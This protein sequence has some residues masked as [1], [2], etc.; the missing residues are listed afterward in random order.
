[1][2]HCILLQLLHRKVKCPFTLRLI[3]KWL[4]SPILIKG[5]LTKRRKGVPQRSP[6]SPLL[7]NIM[8]HKLGKE[9][10]KRQLRC[11]R[12]ADD[13]SIYT[14]SNQAARKVGNQIYLFLQDKLK[15]PI[16]REK[17]GIR[18]PVQFGILGYKF[19]PTRKNGDKGK[20]TAIDEG[21]I[22]YPERNIYGTYY[23]IDGNTASS[24]QFFLT[25]S[26]K[27]YLR[28]AL[29]FNEQPRQDS[30]QP[31]LDFSKRI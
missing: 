17:G 26:T 27:N 15:L 21:V 28:G 3:R 8:L 24:I 19:V 2:D 13:F 11:V 20:P 1:M 10:E 22:A 16:N 6:L 9:L 4:R 30:I 5:K 18:K 23:S 31:V 7:S 14:K 29:Y 12:Y 25:D